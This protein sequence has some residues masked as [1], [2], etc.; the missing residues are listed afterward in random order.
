MALE[1]WQQKPHDPP[2][3]E[4][5]PGHWQ[6]HIAVEPGEAPA[7][8]AA[9]GQVVPT[10]HVEL[11]SERAESGSG[12]GTASDA[13]LALRIYATTATEAT[14]QAGAL[15]RRIRAA[16]GLEPAPTLVLGYISPWWQA[17][18]IPILG[19]EAQ[20]LHQQGR[21]ELAVIRRQT[22]TELAIASALTSLLREQHPHA[23]PA[24]LIRR[25]TTLRD[26]QSKAFLEMLTGRRIQDEDWWRGYIEHLKRRNAIVHEGLV[27]TREDAVASIQ[28]C[29][30]L[31]GWLL[32]AQ[33]APE[34]DDDD[35]N[36]EDEAS[37]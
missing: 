27:I 24:Q 17:N 3:G 20:A 10:E 30:A 15:F 37:R 6:V 1:D 12:G 9:A 36:V 19:R 35:D 32:D 13:L 8:A 25:G 26:D 11:H 18:R 33:G 29:H 23:D 21:H 14:E 28:A 31:R 34:L 7:I 4:P 16:A 5:D 22:A 2:Y